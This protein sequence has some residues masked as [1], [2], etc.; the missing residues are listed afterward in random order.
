MKTKIISSILFITFLLFGCKL[1]DTGGTTE[2]ETQNTN[3]TVTFTGKIIDNST[4]LGIYQAVARLVVDTSNKGTMTDSSGNF[5]FTC[6]VP[7]SNDYPFIAEKDGYYP[8]TLTTFALIGKTITIPTIRLLQKTTISKSDSAKSI[9]LISQSMTSVGVQSSG[10][11]EASNIIF[12]VQDGNGHAVD[13]IHAVTVNFSIGSS[14][15]GGEYLYPLQA[16]TN[17]FGRVHVTLNSGTKA[18]V[19]QVIASYTLNGKTVRSKPVT[20][21][22]FGGLPVTTHFLVACPNL[23]YGYYGIVGKEIDFSAYVGDRYANP[24]R[25][26]TTVYFTTS[27][28]IIGGSAVTN[29]QGVATVALLTEPYPVHNVQGAGFFEV[30]AQTVDEN[31]TTISTSTIRLLTG[32]P[33]ISNVSPTTFNIP[34]AGSQTFTFTVTDALG[35]PMAPGTTINVATQGGS[36]TLFGDTAVKMPD[37]EIGGTGLT[38]FSFSVMDGDPTTIK[39]TP[40][41][42]TI[43]VN[44][45]RGTV[46]YSFTG[47]TN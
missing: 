37:S 35:H 29:D 7:K 20:V 19:V 11:E 34:N 30:T 28:G 32:P 42:I 43:T 15:G 46:S 27:S 33:V 14:P 26:G 40:L 36:V 10:S 4:G 16:V 21:A 1:K 31:S 23:N 5:S 22:I 24:V 3:G 18:G 38:N 17:S 39:P 8:D 44:S 25:P 41:I 6:S 47:T 2:T 13:D 9:M 45:D 12:E